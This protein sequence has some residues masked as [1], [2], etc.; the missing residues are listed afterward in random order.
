MPRVTW[1]S[2]CTTIVGHEEQLEA[3][4]AKM[5]DVLC[6]SVKKPTMIQRTGTYSS[7]AAGKRLTHFDESRQ[8]TGKASDY[9]F[10]TTKKGNEGHLQLTTSLK[11]PIN[12]SMLTHIGSFVNEAKTYNSG[13]SLEI[14]RAHV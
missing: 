8:D 12:H 14:G 9:Q 4:E 10:N 3:S 2:I 5:S 7:I 11:V 13:D 6:S 1:I